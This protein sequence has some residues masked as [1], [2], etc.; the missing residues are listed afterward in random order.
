[1]AH[2]RKQLEKQKY[3]LV[4]YNEAMFTKNVKITPVAIFG[5]KKNSREKAKELGLPHYIS[6]RK[7]Y[8][9]NMK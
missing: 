2:G 1:V 5:Y 7:F 6:T 4:E 8:E 3:R 9:K